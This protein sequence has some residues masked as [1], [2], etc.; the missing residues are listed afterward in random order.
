M[1]K[2]NQRCPESLNMQIMLP[3]FS[4]VASFQKV[5]P[6]FNSTPT[7]TPTQTS[8]QP[9]KPQERPVRKRFRSKHTYDVGYK[10]WENE[11]RTK[12]LTESELDTELTT[13][14][15]NA[16]PKVRE[17]LSKLAIYENILEE[18]SETDTKRFRIGKP[19]FSRIGRTW[20]SRLSSQFGSK[21]LKHGS[22]TN[23]KGIAAKVSK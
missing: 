21:A 2:R 13:K 18:S 16:S 11:K 5:A 9:E 12:C 17:E 1:R 6:T 19:A 20:H 3:W 14:V 10:K 23:H 22:A 15:Q 7:P 4:M 8:K